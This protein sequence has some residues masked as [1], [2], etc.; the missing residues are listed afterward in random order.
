MKITLNNEEKKGHGSN[1]SGNQLFMKE[2]ISTDANNLPENKTEVY[3]T[4][5]IG[6]QL[7]LLLYS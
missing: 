6:K 4:L 2:P 5:P 3:A 7:F 1:N